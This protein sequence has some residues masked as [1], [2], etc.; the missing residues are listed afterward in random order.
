VTLKVLAP[1]LSGDEKNDQNF[2]VM[3]YPRGDD[4]KQRSAQKWDNILFPN[5]EPSNPFT[6]FWRK[7]WI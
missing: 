1:A 3:E 7:I 6:F 5:A 2:L 4:L